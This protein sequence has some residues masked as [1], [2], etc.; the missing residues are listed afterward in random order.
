MSMDVSSTTCWPETHRR[1]AVTSVASANVLAS[2]PP[3]RTA[4]RPWIAGWLG[5]SALGW[6]VA[7]DWAWARLQGW[8]G[9]GDGPWPWFVL[10]AVGLVALSLG[11][12]LH[13]AVRG[14]LG[15]H[16]ARLWLA[17][18][19]LLIGLWIAEV[20]Q[21]WTPGWA[22][23]HGR[24]P[25]TV[26]RFEPDYIVLPGV[27]GMAHSSMNPWG[28]RGT[29]PPDR[30]AAYRVVCLGGSS[31]ECL[32]LDDS[33]TWPAQLQ[34]RWKRPE[35][36]SWVG[37]VAVSDFD[38][39][40]H[41]RWLEQSPLVPEVDC[42]V[43]LV[44]AGDLVRGLL[45]IDSGWPAP[46]R[47]LRLG[48]MDL[49]KQV[50][51]VRMGHGLLVDPEGRLL[52]HNR[53]DRAIESPPGG[54]QLDKLLADYRQ[55]LSK[56]CAAARRRQVRLICVTEPVLWDDFLGD[57]ACQRFWLARTE[58][59]PRSWE[60]LRPGKLREAIDRY[61]LA[62]LEV[63]RR[64]QI[65]VVDAASALSGIEAYFYDD[66]HLNEQGCAVL[67]NLLAEYFSS[68]PTAA[69]EPLPSRA[70]QSIDNSSGD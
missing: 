14:W 32:F 20:G 6:L 64:E 44:G 39:G 60:V 34:A 1:G 38:S 21:R 24:P 61:N 56:L 28:M 43:V 54:W 67:G 42:V 57:E 23:F 2:K 69:G 66:Y 50:W 37:S 59:T 58:P 46:P 49:C 9:Q 51:N 26:Y 55:R 18:A 5:A 10:P 16:A 40:H 13:G 4:G 68:H 7:A 12:S 29:A 62:L 70:S 22:P 65:E 19:A 45:G 3:T 25:G 47:L 63:C 35:G 27:Q 17:S 36:A 8:S 33:E 11:A 52:L 41:L 48:T 53:R 31:T 30:S 15:R